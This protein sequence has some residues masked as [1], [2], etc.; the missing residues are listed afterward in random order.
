[1]SRWMGQLVIWIEVSGPRSR[2]GRKRVILEL[3]DFRTGIQ[4]DVHSL[5]ERLELASGRRVSMPEV[6]YP[7]DRL[8]ARRHISPRMLIVSDKSICRFDGSVLMDLERKLQVSGV[9]MALS[10]RESRD[11]RL[12]AYLQSCIHPAAHGGCP[13]SP[14]AGVHHW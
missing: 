12:P 1:M 14:A 9:T 2:L 3:R 4:M 10:F 13:H 11:D 6:S 7:I 8:P 5:E